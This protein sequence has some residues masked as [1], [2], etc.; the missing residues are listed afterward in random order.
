MSVNGNVLEI[1]DENFAE[2]IEG[3]TGLTMVDFWAEWCGPCKAFAP[4]Y[5][6]AAQ[7]LE[8]AYRLLKVDTEANQAIAMQYRIQSIPTLAIFKKGAEVARQSGAM[9]LTQFIS[10]VRSAT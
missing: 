1:T 6:Q 5:V 8:P 9:S 2:T 10:W 4:I 3:S 7:Q